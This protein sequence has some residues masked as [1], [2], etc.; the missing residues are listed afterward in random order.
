MN[1]LISHHLG[2]GDMIVMNG[3][4]RFIYERDKDKY[5][6]IYLLCYEHNSRN[7]E[8]MYEDLAKL[9]LLIIHQDNQIGGAIDGFIGDKEDFHL[10]QDGYALYDKIGDDAFFT[11]YDKSLRKKFYIRRHDSAEEQVLKKMEWYLN[12]QEYIFIHD[13][14]ERGYEIKN[15]PDG[16]K[17]VRLPK[18]VALFDGLLL[19]ERAKECHVISSAFVCLLQSMPSLNKNVVVHT[20]VRNSHLMP[21]FVSDGLKCI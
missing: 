19:M 13:D 21:Y 4:V 3:L 20:S 11:K 17:K 16:I 7:V 14:V 15:L 12:G 8:R 10:D 2:M 1:K 5:D 9:K 18:D 6:A